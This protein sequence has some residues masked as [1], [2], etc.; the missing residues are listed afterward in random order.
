MN[1]W[2]V[3]SA[4]TVAGSSTEAAISISAHWSRLSIAVDFDGHGIGKLLVL[5]VV[6]RTARKEMPGNL[7][8]LKRNLERRYGRDRRA[9]STG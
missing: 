4:R 6:R 2:R 7:A 8:T 3:T 5:L 1:G 9:C